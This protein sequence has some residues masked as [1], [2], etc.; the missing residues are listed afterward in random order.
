MCVCVCVCVCVRE[1]EHASV[2]HVQSCTCTCMYVYCIHDCM[3]H[4]V[5]RIYVHV[6][7]PVVQCLLHVLEYYL[8]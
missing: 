5:Y 2:V 7:I 6:Y 3:V 1:R 8:T 4:M